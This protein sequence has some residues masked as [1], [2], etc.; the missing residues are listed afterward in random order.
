MNSRRKFLQ[1][2]LLGGS[3]LALMPQLLSASM[4]GSS[5]DNKPPTR[6]IFLHKGN[7][8]LPES[9]VPPTFD[10]KLVEAEKKKEAFSVDLDQHELPKWMSPLSDH[11]DNL[12]ILQGLSGK[13]CTTGHHTWCSSLGVYKANERLSSIK[14]ATVDFEL[15]KLFPSP[16]GH[17]ELACFPGGGGNSRGNINGIEKGFSARGPQQPNY[18]FGSPKVAI[19][20][21]FKSVATDESAKASYE[22]ER[23][24]LEF[25]AK[26]HAKLANQLRGVEQPKVGNYAGA[27][28]DIRDRNGRVEAMGEVIRQNMPKLDEKYLAE[29]IS[30]V[31]RQAGH[32]EILLSSLISG[33]TNVVTFTLDELGTLYSGL[34]DIEGENVNQHDVGHG[35]SVAQFS[36]VQVRE[37]IRSQ[38]MNVIDD[39]VTRL[40]N[41]PEAGG[42]MFDNTVLLYF[43]DN[44]ETHHS[45]G[46][47]WPFVILAGDNARLDLGRRYIRLPGY[48]KE[49]HKT[50]GNWY[51][52][53]LNAYGNPIDH[54]GALDVA[55]TIDQKGP[56]KEFLS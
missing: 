50:L 16:F 23:K 3:S 40:K 5:T 30:T 11:K 12:T 41:V 34:P 45:H 49:G 19:Q 18:A 39:I 44:G 36:A 22:L 27:M 9:L 14:W 46:T 32:T 37:K 1:T 15:A 6:F 26:N 33:M 17:I 52:T 43:P 55:L 10:K 24:M 54:F 20:E 13:M 31:D 2:G 4:A 38:H 51:T 21:L 7:G 48:G 28:Q 47:E 25:V 29:N 53:I 42:T 8:L 35:K 56:M